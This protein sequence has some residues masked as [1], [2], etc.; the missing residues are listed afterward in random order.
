MTVTIFMIFKSQN[1][2]LFFFFSDEGKPGMFLQ[3]F[4][5]FFIVVAVFLNFLS[6]QSFIQAQFFLFISRK[7]YL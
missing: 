5:N 4:L 7:R 1:L 2:T 6:S 3:F